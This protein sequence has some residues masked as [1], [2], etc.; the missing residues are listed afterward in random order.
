MGMRLKFLTST[1]NTS[2]SHYRYAMVGQYTLTYIKNPSKITV[3]KTIAFSKITNGTDKR[4]ANRASGG[5]TTNRQIANDLR[6]IADSN[7]A[8]GKTK[9]MPE[10]RLTGKMKDGAR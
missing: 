8:T 6:L 10:G 2:I 7:M 3:L 1:S 9:E 4:K 5:G